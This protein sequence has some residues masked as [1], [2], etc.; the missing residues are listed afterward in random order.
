[1]LLW[2]VREGPVFGKS[3]KKCNSE[4]QLSNIIL[5]ESHASVSILLHYLLTLFYFLRCGFSWGYANYL[6]TLI[7]RPSLYRY[8]RNAPIKASEQK[9]PT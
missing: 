6:V 3:Y 4:R 2:S 1:M 9:F 8:P 7:Q 5:L